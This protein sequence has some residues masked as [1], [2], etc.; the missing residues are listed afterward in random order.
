MNMELVLIQEL[1]VLLLAI[2]DLFKGE[3]ILK[4]YDFQQFS[5]QV[6]AGSLALE[7]ETILKQSVFALFDNVFDTGLIKAFPF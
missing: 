2:S 4:S 5:L 7:E 3:K 6:L 1:I